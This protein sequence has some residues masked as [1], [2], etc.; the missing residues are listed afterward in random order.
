MPTNLNSVLYMSYQLGY[1]KQLLD[2]TRK[3]LA[4]ERAEVQRLRAVALYAIGEIESYIDCADVTHQLAYSVFGL[5]I[6]SCG[7][8]SGHD[9]VSWSKT[10]DIGLQ[11]GKCSCGNTVSRVMPPDRR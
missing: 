5:V 7:K 3:D 1:Y 6:C 10:S 4:V 9:Q 8:S 2:M 11:C